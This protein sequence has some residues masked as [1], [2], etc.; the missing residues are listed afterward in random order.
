[1]SIRGYF[2]KKLMSLLRHAE[3][4]DAVPTPRVHND[5]ERM[6][7]SVA[8]AI[9][10]FRIDNGF[11]VRT[12]NQQELYEGGMVGGFTYCKDHSAIAEHIVAAEVKR[13]LVGGQQE[14]FSKPV[15]IVGQAHAQVKQRI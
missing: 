1:M 5:M 2:G 11:V 4:L 15:G 3:Q 12:I 10:A 13:K 14:M 6:F 8:P 7:G 9:V